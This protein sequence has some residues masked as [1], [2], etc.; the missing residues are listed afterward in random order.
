MPNILFLKLKFCG[1]INFI[2]S[3]TFLNFY[4]VKNQDLREEA[5]EEILLE[6]SMFIPP[7]ISF[8]YVLALIKE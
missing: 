1:N 3:F 2:Y 4:L 5:K 7:K 8:I 6:T